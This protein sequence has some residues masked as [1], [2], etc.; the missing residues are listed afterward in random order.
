MRS[1][2]MF[3]LIELAVYR[4]SMHLVMASIEG[5]TLSC[6]INHLPSE[7]CRSQKMTQ[8]REKMNTKNT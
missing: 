3:V 4:L 8:N 1:Q 7:N 5:H 6:M 2:Y